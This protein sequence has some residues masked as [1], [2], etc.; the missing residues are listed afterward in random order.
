LNRRGD[1]GTGWS[2]AWKINFWARLHDGERSYSLLKSLLSP[3][4]SKEKKYHDGGTYPNLFCS[5]PPFQI[6]GNFGGIAGV[7][8]MLVQSQEGFVE[9]LPAIPA[10]WAVGEFKGLCVRGGAVLDVAWNTTALVVS[11]ASN[12]KNSSLK[13]KKP[14]GFKRY[15]MHK[16]GVTIAI[17]KDV[18]MIDV[19][20]SKGERVVITCEK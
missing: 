6:D 17:N 1:A 5:H 4:V 8:E 3:A 11:V 20:V 12:V 9:L 10:S 7:A 16:G 13:I 15:S 19:P 18:D 2:R 14:E